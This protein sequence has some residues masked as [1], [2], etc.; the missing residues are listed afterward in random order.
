M[1]YAK[2]TDL[3]ERGWTRRSFNAS[4]DCGQ[5]TKLRRGYYLVEGESSL[6]RIQAN[7]EVCSDKAVVSHGSAA[8]LH[9]LPVPDEAILKAH[10]TRSRRSGGKRKKA[11]KLYGCRLRPD[12][13]TVLQGMVATTLSRTVV[14]FARHH[15]GAW[16]LV[17][18]DAALR[19]GLSMEEL[20][21]QIARGGHR[22]G[23]R[24]ARRV[25]G[26]ADGAAESVGESLSR[27]IMFEAGL[28]M[29]RIQVELDSWGQIVR[30]DFF[31]DDLGLV[32][33]FDGAMKY[34]AQLA[35]GGDAAAA[36]VA[37]KRREDGLR[38]HGYL[39]VRW[40]WDDVM[41]PERLVAILRQ[42][43]RLAERSSTRR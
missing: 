22:P 19:A 24:R 2:T 38:A 42:A 6:A 40:V 7:R 27:W 35:P 15:D 25:V 5:L 1:F 21:E 8:W 37:E 31:W 36:V 29:P 3:L 18:A 9:G 39:V 43:M 11:V 30:V 17:V 23:G 10:F 14:D 28:P 34:G 12:E 20:K 4:V 26:L 41:H 33:E 16:G 32:G 13:M